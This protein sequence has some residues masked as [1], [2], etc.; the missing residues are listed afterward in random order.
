VTSTTKCY[1]SDPSARNF[2]NNHSTS[3]VFIP[4][5]VLLI[6]TSY[7]VRLSRYIRRNC[8]ALGCRGFSTSATPF[9]P[10]KM[11]KY[12]ELSREELIARLEAIDTP[13]GS[14]SRQTLP[15]KSLPRDEY[16]RN[17]R[18]RLDKPFDFPVHPTR[19]IA[20]MLTYHGWPY[21]GLAIQSDPSLATV[22]GELL[23]ALEK[24]HL[25]EHGKG[26]EGC[27]YSRCGRT[28]RGVS[29]EGQVV[30]LYVRSQRKE[31]RGWK[32]P[33]R[34]E[35]D[36]QEH[37][38]TETMDEPDAKPRKPRKE[39]EN[40]FSYPRLLNGVLP[41][42]IRV[43]AWAPVD[44]GFDSRYSCTYRHYKYPFHLDGT[45]DLSL[46]REAAGSFIGTHDFRN[47]CKI[48][49]SKQIEN[50]ARTV[51]KAYFDE[52]EA[53]G[54]V[55]FNLIGTAFLWHQVRHIIA[56]LFLIGRGLE[57]VGMI[58][59]LLDTKTN[60]SK[61][62]YHMGEPLPLTLHE[63]GYPEPLDWRIG[64]YDGPFIS[65][66]PEERKSVWK[67]AMAGRDKLEREF[68]AKKQHAELRSWQ[69][70]G[71]LR[72]LHN[73]MPEEEGEDKGDMV[74]YPVGGGEMKLTA[75]YKKVMERQRGDEPAEV[76]RK[77][78]I[79][80]ARKDA[81]AAAADASDE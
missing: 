48:D 69:I 4:E 30:N 33:E 42:S 40:E 15:L 17:G 18:A 32:A 11:S 25:V 26:F 19:H 1:L 31:G 63:C 13:G 73:I 38:S 10:A 9:N 59:K 47:F 52:T 51:V 46:M 29:G 12:A 70:A 79:T 24:V 75:R 7:I 78:L 2:K 58:K 5:P 34:A 44:E 22:E 21:S 68:I 72:T 53:N 57:D 6:T 62:A 39:H 14:T 36:I 49:G 76:N 77:W 65:L 80:R 28:D 81:L 67:R 20:L 50:H 27:F 54:L 45:L 66:S 71:G 23:K 35:S 61:P 55:V 43:L 16:M 64:G 56:S 60:P 3:P 74:S 37:V 41:P 8:R